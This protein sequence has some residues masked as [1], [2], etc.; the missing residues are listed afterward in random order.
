[1]IPSSVEKRPIP[2]GVILSTIRSNDDLRMSVSI[3]IGN[4]RLIEYGS[5]S[6]RSRKQFL[7][8]ATMKDPQPALI[9]V[10]DFGHA[11]AVEV[12]D[13]R[14]G[15]SRRQILC[16]GLPQNAIIGP[17]TCWVAVSCAQSGL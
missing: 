17:D 11:I 6:H 2:T 7:A 9:T 16:L 4:D 15:A 5:R 3:H 13:R 10:D 14:T 12:E 1:L 8:I